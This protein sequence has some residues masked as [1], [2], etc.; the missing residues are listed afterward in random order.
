MVCPSVR[1]ILKQQRLL[2]YGDW[3]QNK[4]KEKAAVVGKKRRED[5]PTGKCSNKASDARQRQAIC[6]G[7]PQ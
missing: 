5:K 2:D 6:R 3:G 4:A 1:E 7:R